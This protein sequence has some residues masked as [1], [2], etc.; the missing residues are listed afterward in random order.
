MEEETMTS[1][2]SE[3]ELWILELGSGTDSWNWSKW[4]G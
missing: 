4:C 1:N 3:W 2:M